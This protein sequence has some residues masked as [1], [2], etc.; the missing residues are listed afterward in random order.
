MVSWLWTLA[1]I[2]NRITSLGEWCDGHD[3]ILSIAQDRIVRLLRAFLMS[4]IVSL[5]HEIVQ[6]PDT[7]GM[8]WVYQTSQ[9]NWVA[10]KVHYRYLRRCLLGCVTP[11]VSCYSKPLWL[12]QIVLLNSDWSTSIQI[13]FEIPLWNEIVFASEIWSCTKVAAK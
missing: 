5:D 1:V 10:I 4:S 12:K 13:S 8:L 9:R 7:V 6:L 2:D 11:P 3:P